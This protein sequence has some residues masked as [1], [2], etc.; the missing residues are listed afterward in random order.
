[1]KITQNK[2]LALKAVRRGC[3]TN[4]RLVGS[5]YVLNFG[6]SNEQT[7]SYYDAIKTMDEII[8]EAEQALRERE[9]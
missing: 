9:K 4:H 3:N 7:I 5:S 8:E 6:S 2:L 1:M